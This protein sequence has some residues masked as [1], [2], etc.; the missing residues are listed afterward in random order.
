MYLNFKPDRGK[1]TQDQT[2]K[3]QIS[4][5]GKQISKWLSYLHA[6]LNTVQGTMSQEFEHLFVMN[7]SHLNLCKDSRFKDIS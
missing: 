7:P 4:V 3:S 5:S 2:L 6:T 1:M